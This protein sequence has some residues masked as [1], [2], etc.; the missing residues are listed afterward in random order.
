MNR[1]QLSKSLWT[2]V[3]L[4]PTAYR[5]DRHGYELPTL[6]DDWIIDGLG[7]HGVHVINTRTHHV[8]TLGYDHIHHLT[9]NP[10][11]RVGDLRFG[12]L[13]LNVQ[14]VLQGNSLRVRPTF[15]P[16]ER[17]ALREGAVGSRGL[18]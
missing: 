11:R 3:Q 10:D 5:F 2:R 12:F 8:T 16:G 9:G 17:L 6:D 1:A 15:R 7:P 4:Q 14:I 18:H 13:T